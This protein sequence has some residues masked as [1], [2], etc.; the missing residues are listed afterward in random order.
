MDFQLAKKIREQDERFPFFTA[1]TERRRA[2]G[3]ASA[4]DYISTLDSEVLDE[5][6]SVMNRVTM[7]MPIEAEYHFGKFTYRPDLRTSLGDGNGC[8]RPKRAICSLCCAST[9]TAC[10]N[11]LWHCERSEGR[12]LLH[13]PVHGCLHRQ[14]QE[15]PKRGSGRSDRKRTF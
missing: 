12:Q 8:F 11:V 5:I 1:R 2:S 14:T 10:W 9:K 7:D 3:F 4:D 6:H 15:I 13:R